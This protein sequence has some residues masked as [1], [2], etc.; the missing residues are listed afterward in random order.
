[1]ATFSLKTVELIKEINKAIKRYEKKKATPQL[2]NIYKTLVANGT[3]EDNDK[4]YRKLVKV[5]TKA[6]NAG[7]I[8]WNA[9]SGR[10]Q[11]HKGDIQL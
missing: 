2:I 9:I 11:H 10:R 6:R 3:L 4:Q 5:V 7:L 8:S 1:M